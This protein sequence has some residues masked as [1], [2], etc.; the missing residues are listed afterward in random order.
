MAPLK[1][2]ALSL[3]FISFQA[4]GSGYFDTDSEEK[5]YQQGITLRN[6]EQYEEAKDCFGPLAKE[7][8]AK[9]Q[10]NLATCLF[11]LGDKEGAYSW[12]RASSQQGLTLSTGNMKKIKEL[13][14]FYLLLPDEVLSYIVQFLDTKDSIAFSSISRRAYNIA[15]KKLFKNKL[16]YIL[17]DIEF[18]P[19]PDL[20]TLNSRIIVKNGGL[21]IRFRD[22]EHLRSIIDNFPYL[23][24]DKIYLVKDENVKFGNELIPILGDAELTTDYY[25]H[26]RAERHMKVKWREGKNKFDKKEI[27]FTGQII[28]PPNCKI[29]FWPNTKLERQQT[30][31]LTD[32]ES[33][34]SAVSLANNLE[35]VDQQTINILDEC[36]AFVEQM[37]DFSEFYPNVFLIS[38]QDITITKNAMFSDGSFILSG[39]GITNLENDL[40]NI[41]FLKDSQDIFYIN[42]S[43]KTTAIYPI[44]HYSMHGLYRITSPGTIVLAGNIPS[45]SDEYGLFINSGNLTY[46]LNRTESGIFSFRNLSIN[47]DAAGNG[48]LSRM[49]STGLPYYLEQWEE[50]PYIKIPLELLS[51]LKAYTSEFFPP[52]V[53]EESWGPLEISKKDLLCAIKE[54][55]ESKEHVLSLIAEFKSSEN[56]SIEG[57]ISEE[58]ISALLQELGFTEE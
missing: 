35:L 39:N 42:P 38:D 9:A 33:Y 24:A 31:K 12:Y 2:Y 26:V 40:K 10:H 6:L 48:G 11:Y 20:I 5:L 32:P 3:I 56:L 13:N 54:M 1:F 25:I 4:W 50:E 45:I 7:G 18:T 49:Y 29:D 14:L 19:A 8:Y 15:T 52:I 55:A 51:Q 53:Y 58:E 44:A 27:P 41:Q 22:E 21:E 34:L 43:Q 17:K 36:E 16:E 47:G 46:L 23:D 30:L 57:D 37:P 28:F